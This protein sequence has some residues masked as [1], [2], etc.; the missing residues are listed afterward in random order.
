MDLRLVADGFT[1][2]QTYSL[3]RV[4]VEQA[5]GAAVPPDFRLL[6]PS[7]LFDHDIDT[8]A[9]TF[10]VLV[11]SLLTRQLCHYSG[12]RTG[13]RTL[14]FLILK[15]HR[16]IWTHVTMPMSLPVWIRPTSH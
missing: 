11:C 12:N 1:Q 15:P 5:H 10:T 9:I 4:D 7:C 16:R 6:W 14:C 13:A 8:Y 3:T 2:Q